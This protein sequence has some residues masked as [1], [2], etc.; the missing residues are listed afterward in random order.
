M[1]AYSFTGKWRQ[2]DCVI[3]HWTSCPS[4]PEQ[5]PKKGLPINREL[6]KPL[7]VFPFELMNTV[8][9]IHTMKSETN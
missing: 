2:T 3:K 5:G 1:H 7:Q 9:Y 6:Y 8:D 4:E